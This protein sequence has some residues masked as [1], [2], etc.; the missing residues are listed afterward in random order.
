MVIEELSGAV[1]GGQRFWVRVR[2]FPATAYVEVWGDGYDVDCHVATTDVQRDIAAAG[3]GVCD[4]PTHI[5]EVLRAAALVLASQ[6][7]AR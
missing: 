2:Q 1:I 6:A 4:H 7:A 5:V 3:Q